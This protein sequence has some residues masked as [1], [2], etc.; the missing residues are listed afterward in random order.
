MTQRP[1]SVTAI[2]GLFIAAGAVGLAY[3]ATELNSWQ[4]FP[5]EAVWVCLVRLAAIVCGAFL[6][7]GHNW[8]RW[9][10]LVWLAWHVVLSVFHSLEGL[11]IHSLLLAVIGYFLFGTRA[12][13]FFSVGGS[14]RHDASSPA[15]MGRAD[16]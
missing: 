5:Y 12:A 4:P 11:V 7:R 8:A 14:K 16:V 3:H 13:A 2:S 10:A 1:H 6:L 9:G 15:N